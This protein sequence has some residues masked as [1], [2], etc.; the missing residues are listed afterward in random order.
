ML[1]AS[2]IASVLLH[3][4]SAP[5][6]DLFD[7][8]YARG[9]GIETSLKTV[10]AHF[11][12]T[13]TSSLLSRPLVAAGTLT[14]ERPSRIVLHYATPERR[15]VLIDRDALTLDW[16]SRGVHQESDIA[17]AQQ[18]IEKYFLDKSPDQLRRNFRITAAE[19]DDRPGTWRVTMVPIR[20]QI[21]QGLSRLEL[22]IDRTSTLLS[23][24]RMTFP[25]GD[26]KMMAFDHVVVN[27]AVDAGVFST[28]AS[29]SK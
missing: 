19:A 17:A 23:A 5:A 9:R 6:V 3:A 11:T 20:K 13:T 25:N 22:W 1:I 26:T 14:V 2:G 28:G 15:T 24:M 21:L 18:R 16:P 4:A 27:G 8:I 7:E 29:G 12:E 10:T